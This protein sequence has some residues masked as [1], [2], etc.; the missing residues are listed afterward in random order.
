[1]AKVLVFAFNPDSFGGGV[2]DLRNVYETDNSEGKPV[3]DA[4]GYLL[5]AAVR[6]VAQRW[7]NPA[8]IQALHLGSKGQ[9]QRQEDWQRVRARPGDPASD[10]HLVP[11][12]SGYSYLRVSA[13]LCVLE[14]PT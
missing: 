3:V 8:R 14:L 2:A 10:E 11:V 4:E 13:G 12:Q 9:P 6:Q 1:M 5:P 7:A